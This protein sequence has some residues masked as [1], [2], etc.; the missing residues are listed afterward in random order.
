MAAENDAN[1]YRLVHDLLNSGRSVR[2]EDRRRH[3]RRAYPAIQRI[4]PWNGGAFPAETEFFDVACRDLTEGGL[5]FLLESEPES[6]HVVVELHTHGRP[7][8]VAGE[9]VRCQCVALCESGEV[10]SLEREDDR[11]R[12]EVA[13]EDWVEMYLI[14]CRFVRRLQKPR[15]APP[16]A[17]RPTR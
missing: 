6:R 15:L 14:G 4:A 3:R 11:A 9:I 10:E 1:L 2:G 7:I 5:S 16:P 13:C 17:S 8:F 12:M